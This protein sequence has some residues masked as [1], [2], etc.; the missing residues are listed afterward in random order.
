MAGIPIPPIS[1]LAELQVLEH[2]VAAAPARTTTTT[3]TIPPIPQRLESGVPG[4]E[5]VSILMPV[6]GMLMRHDANRRWCGGDGGGGGGGGGGHHGVKNEAVGVVPR[7]VQCVARTNFFPETRRSEFRKRAVIEIPHGL[8]GEGVIVLE[9]TCGMVM[10]AFE[11]CVLRH[12][13]MEV[14]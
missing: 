8:V 9:D 1:F 4:V 10:V 7:E 5:T 6:T 3:T 2:V 14:Q 11:E 13:G 12:H